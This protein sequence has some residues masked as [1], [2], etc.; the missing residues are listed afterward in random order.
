MPNFRSIFISI[1]LPST[2]KMT[3]NA[4]TKQSHFLGAFHAHYGLVVD[5]KPPSRTTA[6]LAA[7]NPE[8]PKSRNPKI[9]K[10]QN[11]QI[12]NP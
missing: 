5:K 6:K 2:C 3:L 7:P 8:I 11:L 4:P 1:R 10:S 9:S 12:P